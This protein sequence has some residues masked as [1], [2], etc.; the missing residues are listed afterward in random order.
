[1]RVSQSKTGS[2]Y[3][4]QHILFLPRQVL[5]HTLW[6]VVTHQT[7]MPHNQLGDYFPALACSSGEVGRTVSITCMRF[8][9][10]WSTLEGKASPVAIC[11]GNENII[12][13][14]P[15]ASIVVGR[16]QTAAD[17]RYPLNTRAIISLFAVSAL[18]ACRGCHDSGG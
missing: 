1:M 10:A 9:S 2:T 12:V 8:W 13:S 4:S 3:H 14:A 11:R 17:A 7:T 18:N 6:Y 5:L 16:E 15:F